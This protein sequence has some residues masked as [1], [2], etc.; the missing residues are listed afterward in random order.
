MLQTPSRN[1]VTAR[2]EPEPAAP[3]QARRFVTETLGYWSCQRLVDDANLLTSELVTNAVLH[4]RTTVELTVCRTDGGVRVEVAD[5]D[6]ERVERTPARR[7][8]ATTGRGLAM[9]AALSDHW[10]VTLARS[11]KSVW[12]E[13]GTGF[14]PRP[15]V[16][17]P[18]VT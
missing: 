18:R 8:H 3:R 4:A 12:F 13:L 9:V 5:D 7:T 2:F 16:G 17:N 15:A 1:Y 6:P 14:R 10:G 11:G